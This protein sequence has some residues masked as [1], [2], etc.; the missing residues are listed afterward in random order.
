[1]AKEKIYGQGIEEAIAKASGSINTRQEFTNVEDALSALRERSKFDPSAAQI[2]VG[3][4]LNFDRTKMKCKISEIGTN[5]ASVVTVPAGMKKADGSVTYDRAINFYLSTPGKSIRVTD[6]NGEPVQDE[7]GAQRVV[8][9]KGN[10]I[11]E[12]CDA[13]KND[14]EVLEY[15]LD[16]QL[17]CTEIRRDFGPSQYVTVGENRVPKGHKLASLP[18]FSEI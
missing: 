15:L 2:L 4:C 17:E 9:G 14:A 1:M 12:A 18:L 7:T 6:A 10:P 5:G 8:T 16:K 11:W 3:M 13:A